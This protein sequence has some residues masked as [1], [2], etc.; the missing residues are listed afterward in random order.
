LKHQAKQH[1][2]RDIAKDC[3]DSRKAELRGEGV[4]GRWYSAIELHLL[5]KLGSTP[6]VSINQVVIKDVLASLWKEKP[7]EATDHPTAEQLHARARQTDPSI[8][9][10]AVFRALTAFANAGL[11]TVLDT[12]RGVFRYE[13]ATIGPHD[14]LADRDTGEL[15]NITSSELDAAVERTASSLGYRVTGRRLIIWAQRIEARPD[16]EFLR[17]YRD[18]RRP[19]AAQRYRNSQRSLSSRSNW[20]PRP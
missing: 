19:P 4:A 3:F 18:L 12:G 8:S 1:L 14:H 11:A 5:P 2:L 16:E 13:D 15:N 10:A 17:N 20:K 6:V 9:R 7:A